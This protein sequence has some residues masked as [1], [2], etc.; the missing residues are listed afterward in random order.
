[1]AL[2]NRPM[3]EQFGARHLGVK[4]PGALT[5]LEEGVMGTL[6][7]DLGSDPMYWFIQGIRVFGGNVYQG[8]VSGEYTKVGLSLESTTST[9]LVRI[10]SWDHWTNSGN[11]FKI[12]R[13]ARTAFSS[14]PGVYGY[15]M[16][17]RIP[18]GQHSSAIIL[19]G[20]GASNPGVTLLQFSDDVESIA[21]SPYMPMI[22]SPGEVIYMSNQTAA[23]HLTGSITW[24]EIDGYKAEL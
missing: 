19:N 6:E 1:M 13:C 17:T 15:G 2:I 4:G 21:R 24:V 11:D 23:A 18:E 16:D 5:Q 3:Y 22:V 10:L 9:K 20:N 8:G 12:H 14:D 7:L